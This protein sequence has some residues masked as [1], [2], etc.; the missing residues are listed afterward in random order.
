[1]LKWSSYITRFLLLFAVCV[2]CM[3]ALSFGLSAYLYT[4]SANAAAAASLTESLRIGRDLLDDY[5]AGTIGQTELRA[6]LNPAVNPDGNF[7][8]LLDAQANVLAYTEAGV[9]YFVSTPREELVR[10]LQEDGAATVHAASSQT[11]ALLMGMK[12]AQGYVLAGRCAP[13]AAARSSSGRGLCFPWA[14]CCC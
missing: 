5:A 11:P 2:M 7:Y 13:S 4:D 3:T 8:M 1:M 12:T 6:A 9:P 14:R 10:S